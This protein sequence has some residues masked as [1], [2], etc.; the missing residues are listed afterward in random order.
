LKQAYETPVIDLKNDY[1]TLCKQLYV[2]LEKEF[3]KPETEIQKI[4]LFYEKEN[5]TDNGIYDIHDSVRILLKHYTS[6]KIIP[7]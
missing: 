3:Q 1:H 5:E 6:T 4:Q 2:I 7:H